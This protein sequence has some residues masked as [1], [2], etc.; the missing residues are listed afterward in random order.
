M[1]YK[2]TNAEENH[3]G[4]Q[5]V[6]GLNIL[7]G[8]F[9]NDPDQSCC[10]GGLYFTNIEN[11]FY[12]LNCGI[13]LREVFLPMSNPGFKMIKDKSGNKW[14]ANMIILGR[15]ASLYNPATFKY[16]IKNG[17]NI[18]AADDY[19]LCY[20]AWYGHLDIIKYLIDNGA[21][22]RTH[23]DL[24]LWLSIGNNHL[25]VYNYLIEKQ[26]KIHAENILEGGANNNLSYWKRTQKVIRSL[27]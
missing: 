4:F 10:K 14:R 9:N 19:V 3:F 24:A 2:I 22:L 5:Y 15:R 20:C 1:Y 12:F 18:H 17:A 23:N 6:T 11:I 13:Y 8:E 7:V 26:R 21:D 16:L 27:L 25:N